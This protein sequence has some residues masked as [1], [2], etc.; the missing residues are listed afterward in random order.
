MLPEGQ[1]H[2]DDPRHDDGPGHH[3]RDDTR[4][5]EDLR[6]MMIQEIGLQA[7]IC[8]LA[9]PPVIVIIDFSS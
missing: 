2:R 7:V 6:M 8:T 9:L 4:D 1:H 5:L 3:H